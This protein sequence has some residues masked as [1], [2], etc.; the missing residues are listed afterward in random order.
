MNAETK[1]SLITLSQKHNRKM[2]SAATSAFLIYNWSGRKG[3]DRRR[4]S[5]AGRPTANKG[6]TQ[7]S[8]CGWEGPDADPGPNAAPQQPGVHP[9]PPAWAG[10]ALCPCPVG[11]EQHQ[12]Q[13]LSCQCS[14]EAAIP[15]FSQAV[16]ITHT[17]TEVWRLEDSWN[18][19][20]PS[21]AAPKPRGAAPVP[22]H[23]LIITLLQAPPQGGESRAPATAPCEGMAGGDGQTPF[24]LCF[25]S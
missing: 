2:S 20:Y 13:F 6:Q 24:C 1:P 23:C 10:A 4:V 19:S 25:T 17:C 5:R 22:I 9:E 7:N 21:Q 14:G 3:M 18:L 15:G 16:L 12:A 11:L 8:S